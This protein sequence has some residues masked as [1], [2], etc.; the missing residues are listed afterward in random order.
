MTWS[1]KAN[2]TSCS[3]T[4]GGDSFVIETCQLP[5]SS[6]PNSQSTPN[7]A[8]PDAQLNPNAQ[9]PT[10]NAQRATPKPKSEGRKSFAAWRDFLLGFLPWEF[11]ALLIWEFLG[12]LRSCGIAELTGELW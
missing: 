7:F 4:A 5:N 10:P 3:S 2:E 9:R 12:E 11:W 8:T 6:T 1:S